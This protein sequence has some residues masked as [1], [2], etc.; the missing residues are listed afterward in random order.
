MESI[1]MSRN[2]WEGKRVFVTG[3]TGFKGGW[4]A[5]WLADMQA[6]VHGYALAPLTEP[7]FFFRMWCGKACCVE[8]LGRHTQCGST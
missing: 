1:C 2:F 5:L 7:N 8:H 4:L 6:E 3:H